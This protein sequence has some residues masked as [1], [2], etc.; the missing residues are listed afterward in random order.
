[1]IEKLLAPVVEDAKLNP[2]L[3]TCESSIADSRIDE[4]IKKIR[5]I[6]LAEALWKPPSV[7]RPSKG[8]RN[9]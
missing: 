5:S 6:A 2:D 7:G 1:M 4:A 3:L 9:A 8:K